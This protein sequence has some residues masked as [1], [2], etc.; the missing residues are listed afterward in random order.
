MRVHAEDQQRVPIK[1][2]APEEWRSGVDQGVRTCHHKGGETVDQDGR[3]A[4]RYG[5]GG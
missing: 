3:T 2:E 1:E 4:A 5:R